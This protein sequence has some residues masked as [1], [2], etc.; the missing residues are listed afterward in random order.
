M[1]FVCV[2]L[3]TAATCGFSRQNVVCGMKTGDFAADILNWYCS[4]SLDEGLFMYFS[5]EDC[6]GSKPC[7]AADALKTYE[8]ND[9]LCH[10]NE[11]VSNPPIKKYRT[12]ANPPQKPI[13]YELQNFDAT[14]PTPSNCCVRNV[15]TSSTSILLEEWY[16]CN[17]VIDFL[18][19]SSTTTGVMLAMCHK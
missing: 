11:K 14:C 12:R 9:Y 7:K 2:F 6:Y 15:C 8:Y 1:G 19:P 17:A 18:M 3:S 13:I 10:L 4:H 16:I 5:A